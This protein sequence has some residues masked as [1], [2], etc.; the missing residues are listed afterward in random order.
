MKYFKLIF[1]HLRSRQN[2]ISPLVFLWNQIKVLICNWTFVRVNI[3]MK[4]RRN[5]MKLR[6]LY[7]MFTTVLEEIKSVRLNVEIKYLQTVL[8]LVAVKLKEKVNR[9]GIS[10]KDITNNEL[11]N[12]HFH[13]YAINIL[14]MFLRY[15]GYF[16][17][18]NRKIVVKHFNQFQ[19]I[20][21]SA[22]RS[23]IYKIFI[24]FFFLCPSSL[25]R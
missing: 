7:L 20:V 8:R 14:N 12:H 25:R 4:S 1:K 16:C 23:G 6:I 19:I 21:I 5:I 10:S 17:M 22:I 3:L 18:T 24:V 15:I 13:H 9:N 11:Q 2:V